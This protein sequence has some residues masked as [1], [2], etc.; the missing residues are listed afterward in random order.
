MCLK[1]QAPHFDAKGITCS[2]KVKIERSSLWKALSNDDEEI[3]IRLWKTRGGLK[4]TLPS[5]GPSK[6]ISPPA[7]SDC[8][9]LELQRDGK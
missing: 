6:D 2:F 9:L 5:H 8:G 4:T 1:L 7:I 3:R